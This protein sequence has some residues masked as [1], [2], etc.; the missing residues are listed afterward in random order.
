MRKFLTL[1]AAAAFALA[2][3]FAGPA[4]AGLTDD[5][6]GYWPF[7]DGADPTDD[8]SVNTNTG[9]LGNGAG[10]DGDDP[11]F[12]SG[13]AD[14][15]PVPGNVSSLDFAAG[16]FVRVAD[17]T[18]L[19][20][21]D[22]TVSVWVRN[23]GAPTSFDY[24]LAKTRDGG[25]AS[26][27]LYTAGSGGLFFYASNAGD[28]FLSDNAGAGIWDGNW[29]H[30]AGIYDSSGPTVHLFVDGVEV[31][32][33]NAGP[34]A[35]DYVTAGGF[36]DLTIGTYNDVAIADWIGN[37]DEVRVY[38][39]ALT[40]GQIA[41]LHN[42]A[43]CAETVVA[44]DSI[45]DAV[46]ANAGFVVCLSDAG[47][48]FHQSVVFG[49]EHSGTTLR[50]ADGESPVMDGSGSADPGTSILADGIQLLDGVS[51]VTI[52]GLEI[53]NYTSTARS[54][55]IQAWA[56]NTSSIA[57]KNNDLNNNLWNGILVGSE[58]AETHTG[59]AVHRNT[60]TNNGFVQIELTNCNSCSIHRNTID[61]RGTFGQM[62]IVVQAR[63][64]VPDSGLV[65]IEGVSVKNNTVDTDRRGVFLL[66][67][68]SQPLPPFDPIDAATSVL[69]GVS[70]GS[71]TITVEGDGT[72]DFDPENEVAVL[73]WGF[74]DGTVIDAN[75]VRNDFVCTDGDG[76]IDEDEGIPGIW[77]REGATLQVIRAKNLNNDVFG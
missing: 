40:A 51:D 22:V 58:G 42:P 16:D 76:N 32:T 36:G 64:T 59:W 60:V 57:V 41:A 73:V 23:N 72:D 68:A 49:P 71:N 21:T 20:P 35:I 65:T 53:T 69:E 29:H 39:V 33:P 45:Q 24:I 62:G 43:L 61:A 30:I 37:I 1:T 2:V 31:G 12:V 67:L 52:K 4:Q 14:I 27:A 66:A 7:D 26:Y 11:A 17:N 19:E 46:D 13:A 34:G 56:V 38:D 3:G 44:D 15:A 9:T 75:I 5:L 74:A 54:S 77:T 28:F 10:V 18:D 50:N 8:A 48:E 6:V 25:K 55:A 47:G 70:V 63:N